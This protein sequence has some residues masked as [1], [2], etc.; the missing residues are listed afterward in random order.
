[1]NVFR[2]PHTNAILISVVSLFYAL[3]FILISGHMEFER[4]L[5]HADT[6][7]STFWNVWSEFL[8]QGNMKYIGYNYIVIALVIVILSLVRKR[9]YDEYQIGILEKG[10][11]VM[12]AIMIVLFPIALIMVLSDPSY[13]IETMMFLVVSHWSIVLIADLIYV[14]RWVKS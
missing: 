8:K 10:I 1:M 6:L 14:I 4:L 13:C 2:K 5:K 11:V 12:G 9:D 7:N 3:V